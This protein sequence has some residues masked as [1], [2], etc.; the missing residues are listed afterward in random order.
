M[1]V[2]DMVN[3]AV[4]AVVVTTVVVEEVE[5]ALGAK[6]RVNGV[7]PRPPE[8]V[9]TARARRMPAASPI[10]KRFPSIISP[11]SLEGR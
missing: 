9:T 6:D 3:V 2:D 1:V 8:A 4:A 7:E 11:P 5:A 10:P